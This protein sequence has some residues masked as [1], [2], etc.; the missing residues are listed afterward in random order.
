MRWAVAVAMVLAGARAAAAHD[1]K[2]RR[3]LEVR[4]RGASVDVVLVAIEE[5]EQAR[6]LR[7]RADADRD[8]R[9]TR[10]ERMRLCELAIVLAYAQLHLQSRGEAVTVGAPAMQ[11]APGSE[12]G[13][14]PVVARARWRRKL[15]LRG[16]TLVVVSEGA[17]PVTVLVKNAGGKLVA[18]GVASRGHELVLTL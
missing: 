15:D 8:G 6:A 2:P 5:G 1:A 17:V 18:Q 14:A 7:E 4:Q 11:A 3:T 13:T 10:A 12:V 9:L 16:R